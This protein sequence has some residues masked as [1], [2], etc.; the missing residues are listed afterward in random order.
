LSLNPHTIERERQREK[1]R[2]TE[3]E[4]ERERE[5]ER[6]RDREGEREFL[7]VISVNVCRTKLH[8][9]FTTN[10]GY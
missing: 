9:Y 8:S 10:I 7:T 1:E 5:R 2:E 3:G 6:E 4:I